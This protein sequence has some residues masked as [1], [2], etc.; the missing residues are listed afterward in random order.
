MGANPEAVERVRVAIEE[1]LRDPVR[2]GELALARSVWLVRAQTW[3]GH[4]RASVERTAP[5]LRQVS[6]TAPF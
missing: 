3:S 2:D 5:Q 4:R 6:Q 1:V